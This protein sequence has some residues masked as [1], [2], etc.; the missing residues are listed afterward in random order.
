MRIQ[1]LNEYSKYDEMVNDFIYN[2][3]HFKLNEGK[4]EDKTYKKIIKDLKLNVNLIGIF[5]AGIGAFYPIVEKLMSG[6]SVELTTESVVLATICALSILYLEG[7]K[8]KKVDEEALRTDSKSMLEE[9]K[10]RGIGNG[11]VKKIIAAF[12]SI[13][14]IFTTI[15]K[16]TGSVINGFIDMFA[17]TALLIPVMNAV[18][19][20]IGKYDLNLE[21]LVANFAGL[22]VGIGTVVA[23][24]A[25]TDIISKLK[26][27][28][29]IKKDKIIGDIKTP[30]IQKFGDKEFG[31][32]YGDDVEI[33]Q[34]Q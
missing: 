16:H 13:K 24:H 23:K 25:I 29:D 27:K 4:S 1:R 28:I 9:L 8:T 6:L 17:Y 15:T 12:D 30:V 10:L 26:D 33:I 31:K 14:N 7:K 32:P 19:F 2:L 22:T 11:I 20:I 21:T 3:E 34:E 5:G 18:K